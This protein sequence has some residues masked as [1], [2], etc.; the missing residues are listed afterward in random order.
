M[1]RDSFI[2]HI[3]TEDAYED[4]ADDVEKDLIYQIMKLIDHCLQVKTKK[5]IGLMK[6]DLEGKILTEFL[7]LWPKTY[8][9]LM[10]DGNSDKKAKGTKKF[11]IKR[12]LMFN[13]KNCLLSNANILKSQKWFK[14][15]AHNVRTEEINNIAFSSNCEKRLE[16]FDRITFYPYDASAGKVRK[17]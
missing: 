10:D 6:N 9:Y 8:S 12:I 14:S 15:E 11:V 1:D 13:D 7:A 5:V 17:T 3:K 16:T 2:I 4:V